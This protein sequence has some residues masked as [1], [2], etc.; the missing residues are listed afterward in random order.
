M[1]V[2]RLIVFLYPKHLIIFGVLI[3]HFWTGVLLM[4]I[5]I[6]FLKKQK[7]FNFLIFGVGLGLFIDEF[8]FMLLGGGDFPQYWSLF[9]ITA[10]IVLLISAYRIRKDIDTI[11]NK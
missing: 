7:K 4:L 8:G 10:T 1:L 9:P 6:L 11:I 2:V 3:H 5:A